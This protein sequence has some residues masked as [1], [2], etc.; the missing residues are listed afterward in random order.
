MF[1]HY[2]TSCKFGLGLYQPLLELARQML[3]KNNLQ[4][5]TN[6]SACTS[7]VNLVLVEHETQEL[8]KI[9][10]L[11]YKYFC[12]CFA[13]TPSPLRYASGEKAL[14]S[15]ITNFLLGTK[16]QEA[17]KYDEQHFCEKIVLKKKEKQGFFSF[18]WLKF[19]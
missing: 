2:R 6:F 11:E 1:P 12:T 10:P 14:F 5:I 19:W 9:E 18:S 17:Y 7:T 15:K 8:P 16:C 13:E 4:F 3:E